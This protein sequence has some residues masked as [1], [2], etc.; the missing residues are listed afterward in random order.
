MPL[1]PHC[2]NSSRAPLW[3]SSTTPRG[4]PVPG[5]LRPQPS[6]LPARCLAP[7]GRQMGTEEAFRSS[8]SFVQNELAE[9]ESEGLLQNGP[10]MARMVAE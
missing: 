7:P 8:N 6:D 4:N 9:L 3:I 1:S 5:W 2:S 10:A